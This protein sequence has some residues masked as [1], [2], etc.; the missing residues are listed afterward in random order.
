MHPVTQMFDLIE[1]PI[2]FAL[3]RWAVESKVFD[4][5]ENGI[6]AADLA[7]EIKGDVERTNRA[8]QA[9]VAAEFLTYGDKKYRLRGDLAPYLLSTS[10]QC[11]NQTFLDLSQTR[12]AGL[13]QFEKLI[14][15]A[16]PSGIPKAFD[17]AHWQRQQR[18]LSIFHRSVAA[19]VMLD[20]LQTVPQWQN[21]NSLLDLGGGSTELAVDIRTLR[22]D[23]TV[24]VFDLPGLIENLAPMRDPG[25]MA[26]A[27]NY[28]DPQTLPSGP[29]DIVWCSMSLYFAEDLTATLANL[30]TCLNPGGTLISFHEDL[31][32]DRCHPMRHVI[33]RTMPALAGQDLSFSGGFI[34]KTMREVNLII[35]SSKHIETPFGPFRLDV[36]R[37]D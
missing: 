19:E 20:A 9:L 27:G 24:A 1:G 22:P 26:Y 28:N 35:Q 13:D 31:S 21:A 18:S 23:M 29:F 30:S 25:I 2:R 3:V 32:E 33:G 6:S 4:H 10:K 17:A 15:G 11:I 36:G 5:C 7:A 12:H 14:A 16:R 37:K 8:L 34:A